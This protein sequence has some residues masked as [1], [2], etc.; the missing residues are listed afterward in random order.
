MLVTKKNYNSYLNILEN[1]EDTLCRELLQMFKECGMNYLNIGCVGNSI[2]SGYSKGDEMISFFARSKMYELGENINFYSFARIRK[3]EESNILKWYSQN[4]T[5]T[6]INRLLIDDL[7]IKQDRYVCYGERQRQKYENIMYSVDVGFKDYIQLGNNIVIYSGLS[8]TFTDVFR[9][10]TLK[11][12]IHILRSFKEDFE[13]L[14]I[15]FVQFYME[16]PQ[17]QIY[18]CGLPDIFGIGLTNLFDIYIK[19]AV[20]MVPNA[21]YLK[22]APKNI[23]LFL[24]NQKEPDYHYS[25]PEYLILLCKIWKTV[26]INYI[27]LKMKNEI[28]IELRQYNNEIEMKDTA[29]K[30]SFAEIESMIKKYERKYAE[31][32]KKYRINLNSIKKKIWRYYNA[33]YL[34][35]FGC[36][37]RRDVR[38]ALFAE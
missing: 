15:L 2:A 18:V 28:L 35:E 30:G 24:E 12:R 4:I 5:H 3:N 32:L 20:S 33:N 34:G 16:N 26:L 21:V 6:D 36:T 31:C 9:N 25:R 23:L 7:R 19:K 22:G 14:K 29:G 37:N 27:P 38:R 10:G 8:G 17:I 1:K 13:Y 11:E